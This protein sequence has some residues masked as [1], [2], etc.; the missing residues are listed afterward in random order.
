RR[1]LSARYSW[2]RRNKELIVFHPSPRQFNPKAKQMTGTK[3][4][5]GENTTGAFSSHK[6]SP[7]CVSLS[8][9]T[10]TTSPVRAEATGCCFLP[11]KWNRCPRR[12]FVSRVELYTTES[13][14]TLPE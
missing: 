1:I 11:S 8:L 3:S 7:V 10:A 2:L 4:T 13:L 6:V 5:N 14:S 12:S 9:G